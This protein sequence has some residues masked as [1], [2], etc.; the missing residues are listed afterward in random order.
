ML[1][2]FLLLVFQTVAYFEKQ[3]DFGPW[4]ENL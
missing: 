4:V 3:T 1:L 2:L